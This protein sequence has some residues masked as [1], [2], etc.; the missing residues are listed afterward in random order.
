MAHQPAKMAFTVLISVLL[1]VFSCAYLSPE[2]V[3]VQEVQQSS[4][5]FLDRTV[6]WGGIIIETAGPDNS[7]IKVSRTDLDQQGRPSL[8]EQ[9]NGFYVVRLNGSFDPKKYRN[10]R[11]IRVTGKITGVQQETLEG[12][13]YEYPVLTAAQ[14]RIWSKEELIGLNH[15]YWHND[16]FWWPHVSFFGRCPGYPSPI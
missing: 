15:F 2:A 8:V 11:L 12:K 13:P 5:A 10:G 14:I 6:T 4:K 16:Y 7:S 1:V 9:S 3:T